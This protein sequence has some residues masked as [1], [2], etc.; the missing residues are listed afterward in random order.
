MAQV[1][2]RGVAFVFAALLSAAACG[3]S[4]SSSGSSPAPIAAHEVE[5]AA[6]GS[7][8]VEALAAG[9]NAV[10]FDIF[11]AAS[12]GSTDDVLVSPLSIGVAFGMADVGAT[13]RTAEVLEE[14]FSYPAD[15]EACWSAFN[16]LEQSV[17]DAGAPTVRLAN[18]LFPDVSFEMV[19]GY[20]ETLARWFGARA[21]PLPLQDESQA[22]RGRINAWVA[23]RTEDLI[24]ELL[25]EGMVNGRSVL[26]L[27]N[28]LYLEADWARQFG[29]Y[30]TEDAPFT[31]LDGTEVTVP[32]M[33]ERELTGPAV[34]TETYSATEVPY[35][36]GR[37]SMLVIVPA[38]GRYEEVEA[39]LSNE[40]VAEIDAAATTGTVELFLP[41]FESSTNL[42]L[43]E[44]FEE[45]L[46]V[47]AVFGPGGSWDGIA[48]GITLESGVHAADISVDEYGTVAAAATAL[49]FE[50]SGAG[51]ADVIV[52]A[53]RPFLY[54][55][56]HQSTGAVFF[57]GR[58]TDP[59]A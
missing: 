15:G 9:L 51:E 46:G 2:L 54:L 52:R 22:S 13:A 17:T 33:H 35:E 30:P 39:S 20:D 1:G 56:R 32:L 57:V 47:D 18:R 49:G 10:G 53:D 28:A 6:A 43:R 34:A 55:I 58:V 11:R 41:R 37:L 40:F 27:V 29:K 4:T 31:R 5:R 16:T 42:N 50:E 23:D 38:E 3:G 12:A 45:H 14:L 26:V 21:E 7:P 48:R 25:P 19:E 8:D 59:A 44:V 36:D 24:P